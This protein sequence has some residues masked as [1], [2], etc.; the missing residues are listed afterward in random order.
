[1]GWGSRIDLSLIPSISMCLPLT[2][3]SR[4]KTHRVISYIPGIY[5]LQADTFQ[6][7]HRIQRS[8]LACPPAHRLQ[9]RCSEHYHVRSISAPDIYIHT[10]IYIYIQYA[11]FLLQ[12]TSHTDLLLLKVHPSVPPFLFKPF[13]LALSPA[14]AGGR[15]QKNG[16]QCIKILW[17]TTG[18]PPCK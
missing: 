17:M 2:Q 15:R 11:I 16:E 14:C 3:P 6:G 9:G 5:I 1:M 7:R 10:Y 8:F 18:T 13:S 4:K 12:D